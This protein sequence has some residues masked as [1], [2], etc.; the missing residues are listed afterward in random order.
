MSGELTLDGVTE[1][2][3]LLQLEPSRPLALDVAEV[4]FAD[5]A[6]VTFLTHCQ[7]VGI[8]LPNCPNYILEWIKA[9]RDNA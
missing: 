3:R 4:T 6:A 2:Q 5:R 1:L 7:A 8:R 9:E